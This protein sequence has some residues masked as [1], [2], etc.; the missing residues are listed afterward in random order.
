MAQIERSALVAY[1]AQQMFDLINDVEAYPQYMDGCVG[2]TVLHSSPEALEARLQL[3]KAGITQSFVTR[4]QLEPPHTM[5]MQLVEGPF[6]RFEGVW[7][8]KALAED[9]CKVQLQM[10]FEFANKV[11]G[12]AAS[13]WFESMASSQVD[14]LCVRAKVIYG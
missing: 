1:S 8:F 3:S 2:A 14:A 10:D 9:A 5:T 11:L 6:S 13:K 12:L 7:S 4:N